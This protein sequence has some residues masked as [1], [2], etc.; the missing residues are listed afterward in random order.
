M[1]KLLFVLALL[2]TVAHA[3]QQPP[4]KAAKLAGC[5]TFA[6]T[7]IPY[8]GRSLQQQLSEPCVDHNAY[9]NSLTAADWAKLLESDREWHEKNRR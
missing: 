7:N 3:Q 5:E 6:M 1:R 4:P 2:P 8:V 9:Y